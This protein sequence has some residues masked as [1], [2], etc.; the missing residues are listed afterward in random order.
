ML[1]LAAVLAAVTV[2]AACA[3]SRPTEGPPAHSRAPMN[4]ESTI[5]SYFDLTG[6]PAHRRLAFGTPEASPCVLLGGGGRHLGWV[7]PVIY[8]TTLAANQ[9][10]P[11]TAAARAS[12]TRLNAGGTVSMDEV[13]ITGTRYFFWFSSDTLSGVTRRGDLCP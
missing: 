2:L 8:D 12:P 10:A 11:N 5:S 7:V 9:P 6:A 13:S 4:Y 1:R 3:T